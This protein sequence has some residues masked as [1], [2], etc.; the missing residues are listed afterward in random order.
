MTAHAHLEEGQDSGASALPTG[1]SSAAPIEPATPSRP[2]ASIPSRVSMPWIAER[3]YLLL[4]SY[5][6]NDNADCTEG[7]PCRA[8]LAMCNVFK[9]ADESPSYLRQFGE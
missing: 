8:C 1:L 3:E 5:C 7:R 4:A 9:V 6:G 2:E